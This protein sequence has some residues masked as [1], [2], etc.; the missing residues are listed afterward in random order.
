MKSYNL[1][2]MFEIS[3]DRL[4]PVIFP[5]SRQVLLTLSG[6]QCREGKQLNLY[7]ILEE[8][9]GFYSEVFQMTEGMEE[10][11]EA[12]RQYIE[13]FTFIDDDSAKD[14]L[15]SDIASLEFRVLMVKTEREVFADSKQ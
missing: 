8:F 12:L 1:D 3:P 15:V 10:H 9:R 7:R 5:Y 14:V 11:L 4:S 13:N 6:H 2:Y